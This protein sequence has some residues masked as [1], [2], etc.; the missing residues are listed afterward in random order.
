MAHLITKATKATKD[1]NEGDLVRFGAREL[2]VEVVTDNDDGTFDLA[3]FLVVNGAA[4][5]RV[6]SITNVPGEATLEVWA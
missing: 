5:A 3:G 2:L 6:T 1:L 4:Q